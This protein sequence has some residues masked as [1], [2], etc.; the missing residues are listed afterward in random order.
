[1]TIPTNTKKRTLPELFVSAGALDDALFAAE[2]AGVGVV[3]I[4]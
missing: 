2:V 4:V 1:M 3:E